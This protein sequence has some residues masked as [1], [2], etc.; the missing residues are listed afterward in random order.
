MLTRLQKSPISFRRHR[1]LMIFTRYPGTLKA[2][3]T[4]FDVLV[5]MAACLPAAWVSSY[6][7]GG[8]K[9]VVFVISYLVFGC[10]LWS[11]IFLWLLPLIRRR[12]QSGPDSKS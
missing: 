9:K 5:F 10:A 4:I 11:F 6:F 7:H 1:A 3:M 12:Q 2:G 8:W